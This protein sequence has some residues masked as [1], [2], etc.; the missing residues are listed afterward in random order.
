MLNILVLTRKKE[1]IQKHDTFAT[2]GLRTYLS[3]AWLLGNSVSF[4]DHKE[5][6]WALK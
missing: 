4:A 6:G 5:E 2:A 3:T 1:R